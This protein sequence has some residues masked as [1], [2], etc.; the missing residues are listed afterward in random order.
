M[1]LLQKCHAVVAAL[2]TYPRAGEFLEYTPDQL[3]GRV[4]NRSDALSFHRLL[5]A[6]QFHSSL[7]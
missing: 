1:C 4:S 7:P 3:D 2:L 5:D 6:R